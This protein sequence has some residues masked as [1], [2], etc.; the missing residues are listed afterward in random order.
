MDQTKSDVR[1]GMQIDWDV[2]IPMEDG[3]VLRAD[4]YR[5]IEEGEYSVIMTYGPYGKY[6]HFEDLY[7]TCWTRMVE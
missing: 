6:L 3:I 4:V 5:P 7:D 2:P 1:D